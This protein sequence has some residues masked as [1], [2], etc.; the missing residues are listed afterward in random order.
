MIQSYST[1]N[2]IDLDPFY[3][4]DIAMTLN[5]TYEKLFIMCMTPPVL[6]TPWYSGN[7]LQI[8]KEELI[9]MPNL[10]EGDSVFTH[11][12]YSGLMG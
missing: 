7:R 9:P 1:Y 10:S 3:L 5:G 4:V 2:R 11:D 8:L 6:M 12:A